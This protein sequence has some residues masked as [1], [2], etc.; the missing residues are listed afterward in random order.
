MND[1]FILFSFYESL[2]LLF[3]WSLLCFGLGFVV[4]LS[5]WDKK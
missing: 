2:F 5:A 3:V 1:N 4:C